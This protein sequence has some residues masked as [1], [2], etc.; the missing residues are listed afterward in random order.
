MDIACTNVFGYLKG[1]KL[2]TPQPSLLLN[3]GPLESFYNQLRELYLI[4]KLVA[5]GRGRTMFRLTEIRPRLDI[6]R[7]FEAGVTARV[8]RYFADNPSIA[9]CIAEIW[10]QT[11]INVQKDKDKVVQEFDVLLVLKNAVLLHLEC[12]TGG[13]ETKDMDARLLNITQAGSSLARQYLVAP[14]FT[15]YSQALWFRAMHETAQKIGTVR[16]APPL[17]FTLPGQPP[18]YHY[19]GAQGK[20]ETF[21]I[22][23][24]E[25]SL[26]K[27]LRPYLP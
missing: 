2:L 22:E 8:Q 25:D 18:S 15:A 7:I 11:K 19:P 26:T 17:Y 20:P 1:L 24:F 10:M 4:A 16:S 3:I 27:I 12:K 21:T 13:I 5:P 14:V 6:G 9:A 23:P